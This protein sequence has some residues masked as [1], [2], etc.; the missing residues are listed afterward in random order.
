MLSK[1]SA[2]SHLETP[3]YLLG[4]VDVRVLFYGKRKKDRCNVL[5]PFVK[6][7]L[8]FLGISKTFFLISRAM[9]LL[10]SCLLFVVKA[11]SFFLLYA[12]GSVPAALNLLDSTTGCS[13]Y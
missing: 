9:P 11:I 12:A 3:F 7:N 2:E 8:G 1:Y 13:A 4:L 5:G 6:C 10:F